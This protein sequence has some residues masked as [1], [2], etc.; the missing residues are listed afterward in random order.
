MN[1]ELAEIRFDREGP[2]ATITFARP[3]K[4]NALSPALIEET[5]RTVEQVAESDARVLIL[6]GEGKSFSAG[7]DLTAVQAASRDV[8]RALSE[9]ARKLIVLLETIPQVTIARVTGHCFTGGL[10]VALGADFILCAEDAVFAD[11]HGKIGLHPGWGLSQRLPR[12]IGQQR[13]REMSFTARRISGTEA[14][15]IGLVLEALPIDKLDARIDEMVEQIVSNSGDAIAAYKALYRAAETMTLDDGLVYE[16][17]TRFK[18]SDARERMAAA[19]TN[20]N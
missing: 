14:A 6:R 13:A 4:L 11:T 16:A 19:P 12:R 3:Q 20:K 18:I 9:N 10:E 7:V 15:A 5:L 8:R 2:R 1:G 17:N